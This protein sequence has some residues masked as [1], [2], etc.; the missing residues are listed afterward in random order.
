MPEDQKYISRDLMRTI[1]EYV[2]MIER[3]DLAKKCIEFHLEFCKM[4]NHVMYFGSICHEILKDDDIII[5]VNGCKYLLRNTMTINGHRVFIDMVSYKFVQEVYIK[6][7]QDNVCIY[8]GNT[9]I[10]LGID[11]LIRGLVD[12]VEFMDLSIGSVIKI[13]EGPR[14]I[15]MGSFKM[16]YQDSQWNTYDE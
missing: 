15:I 9:S 3:I 14:R 5:E 8:S 1:S 11:R 4:G 10:I 2:P 7:D 16:I 13:V 6:M 12:S